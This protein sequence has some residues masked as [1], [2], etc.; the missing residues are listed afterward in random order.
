MKGEAGSDGTCPA[1]CRYSKNYIY[2]EFVNFTYQTDEL[3]P[4][5]TKLQETLEALKKR[6]EVLE[7]N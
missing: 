3:F 7:N 5:I 2:L 1:N 6:I 4:Q